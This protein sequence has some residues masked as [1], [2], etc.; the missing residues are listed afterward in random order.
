MAAITSSRIEL[1][2]AAPK[3]SDNTPRL[4][5]SAKAMTS[6]PLD[7]ASLDFRVTVLGLLSLLAFFKLLASII[8]LSKRRRCWRRTVHY[9]TT[10][11]WS[12]PGWP[13]ATTQSQT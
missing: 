13:D 4:I 8:A 11:N 5:E 3:N 6:E 2:P 1:L 12:A 10:A 9:Y 7:T